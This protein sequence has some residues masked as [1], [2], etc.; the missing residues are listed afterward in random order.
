[1]A[2]VQDLQAENATRA[3]KEAAEQ[4]AYEPPT[5]RRERTVR[6]S[7]KQKNDLKYHDWTRLKHVME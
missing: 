7:D 2:T 5:D 1:M 6:L 4:P 3:Q